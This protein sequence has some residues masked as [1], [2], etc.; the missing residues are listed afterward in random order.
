MKMALI[1]SSGGHLFELLRIRDFW[2]AVEHFWVT[3][4][5][6]DARCLLADETTTYWAYYPTNRNLTNLIRN[7]WLA[8]KLLRKERPDVI[9]TTGA[10]VAVPFIFL[11]RLLGIRT[12]YLES[13][14]RISELSL[15]GHLVYPIA[16]RFIVQWDG[17]A[18]RYRRAEYHG[19]IV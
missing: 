7:T 5:T 4:P 14:T 9:L 6:E 2:D 16:D 17:L 1:A 18:Q 11:G 13:L 15:T 8:W 19:K 12:I 3:F 10:G